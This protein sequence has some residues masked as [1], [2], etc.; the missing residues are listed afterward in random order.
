[1]VPYIAIFVISIGLFGLSDKVKRT[2]KKPLIFIGIA[3]LCLL[4]GLRAESIGTDTRV[5][6]MPIYEAAKRCN[7]ISEYLNSSFH[8]FSWTTDYVKEMEP[9]FP[10]LI[11]V[12]TK[13]TGSIYCVQTVLEICA[14]LPLYLAVKKRNSISLWIAMF[15]FCMAFYNPSMNMMRQSI[16][17]S[18]GVLGFEYWREEERK[19]SFVCVIISFLFH[20]SALLLLLIYFMYD[21]N[22]NCNVIS[23]KK[24]KK[25]HRNEIPRLMISVGVGVAGMLLASA[26]VSILSTVGFGQY[27]SYVAGTLTFM[28]N[29][30]IIRIPQ[31]VLLI[32]SYKY[33]KWKGV[34]VNFFLLMEIFAVLFSQFTSVSGYGGRIALYF[35]IF[36]I[37]V[38]PLAMD[39]LKKVNSGFFIRPAIIGYYMFYWWYYYVFTGAHQTVPY[40]FIK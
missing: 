32:W 5:Y 24:D 20:K 26:I 2:Q 13:L 7:S 23:F 27:V 4:A 10:F 30:L 21:Y 18:L 34:E 22:V 29:Q 8:A 37:L 25:S 1:M 15:V 36:D 40:I 17:M 19:Q 16:A 38:I 31:I 6:L 12:V 11:L 33:L 14:I 35:G 28:P 39:A 9:L 3:L